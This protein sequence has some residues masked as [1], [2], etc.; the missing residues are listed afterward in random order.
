[1]VQILPANERES[2]GS[3]IGRGLGEGFGKGVSQASD[4][5]MKIAEQKY[6]TAQRQKMLEQIEGESPQS[7]R[8]PTFQDQLQSVLPHIEEQ[9]G[10]KLTPDQIQ[11]VSNQLMGE[12]SNEQ[13]PQ[14]QE[15]DPFLKAK[16]YAAVGEHD[17]ATIAG[18]EAQVGIEEKRENRKLSQAEKIAKRKE[19]I[20][21]HQESKDYDEELLKNKKSASNQLEAIKDT[22]K[23]I[24][25]GNV[26]PS[27]LANVF[28]FFGPIGEKLSNAILNKDEAAIQGSIPAFL[29][30]RKELFGVRL[31]D[32]DLRLLQDKMP[33]I[34][35]SEAANKTVIRIMRKYSEKSLLR[36]EIG[37]DIKE[38][39]KGLRPLNYSSAIE[40][41]YDDMTKDVK[42]LNPK[43]GNV[44]DIPAYKV[45]DAIKAGG[46]LVDE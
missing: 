1:M 13:P 31:S 26:K 15:Q 35:K 9:L 11:S 14:Q 37:Q 2:F 10:F 38:K 12:G 19:E 41:R 25:S 22:E 36:Y 39:N 33:D 43:T 3:T 5:A 23:A 4:F 28:K 34:G 44:V 29:E 45:G 46:T 16:K 21:F 8:Q 42:I 6:K 24:A 30:G 40:K 27:S 18:K 32:A 20:L 17:L 7:T